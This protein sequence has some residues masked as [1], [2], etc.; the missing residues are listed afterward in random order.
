MGFS[1]E[2][3]CS[4]RAGCFRVPFENGK[5]QVSALNDKPVHGI[6]GDG[7]ADFA[8]EFLNCGHGFSIVSIFMV[9]LVDG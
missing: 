1:A 5:V 9:A 3:P 7:A 4:R 2:V 8:T 6:A